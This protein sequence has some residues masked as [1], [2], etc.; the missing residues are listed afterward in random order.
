MW[1]GQA[2]P[3]ARELTT[4]QL[5]ATLEQETLEALDRLAGLHK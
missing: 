1:A 5:I 4:A 2:A 3:L